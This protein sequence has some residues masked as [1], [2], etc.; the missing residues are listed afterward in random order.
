MPD[1]SMTDP[2]NPNVRVYF[3]EGPSPYLMVAVKVDIA[4]RIV[5]TAH[6]AK[7]ETGAQIEWPQP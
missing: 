4:K 3:G 5:V 7:K 2:T 6:L 1:S